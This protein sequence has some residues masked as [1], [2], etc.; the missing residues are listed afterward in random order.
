MQDQAS[1]YTWDHAAAAISVG[2]IIICGFLHLSRRRY[3]FFRTLQHT[4]QLSAVSLPHNLQF[5]LF[6][7]Y[8]PHVGR[9][10]FKLTFLKNSIK[11]KFC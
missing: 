11:C 3:F 7:L 1:K 6:T 8:W 4:V 9:V 2:Y 5:V 10:I